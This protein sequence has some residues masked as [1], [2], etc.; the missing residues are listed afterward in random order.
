V[1]LV[2]SIAWRGASRRDACVVNQPRVG[3][4][5]PRPDGMHL[6]RFQPSRV[7]DSQGLHP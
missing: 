7:R 4:V 6:E 1:M 3:G 5:T 2:V